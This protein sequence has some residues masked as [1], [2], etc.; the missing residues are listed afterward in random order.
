MLYQFYPFLLILLLLLLYKF[1]MRTMA[2]DDT[3]SI[4]L[5]DKNVLCFY[6]FSFYFYLF[7]SAIHVTTMTMHS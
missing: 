2:L 5:A 6:L 4:G 1:V 3:K 7:V